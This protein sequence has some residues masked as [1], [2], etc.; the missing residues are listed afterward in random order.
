MNLRMLVDCWGCRGT[1]A[2]FCAACVSQALS[3]RHAR[4]RDFASDKKQLEASMAEAIAAR[5]AL[6]RQRAER[7]THR[8]LIDELNME[9]KTI[10]RESRCLEEEMSPCVRPCP[11]AARHQQQRL[12]GA[13]AIAQQTAAAMAAATPAAMAPA[14]LLAPRCLRARNRQLLPRRALPPLRPLISSSRNAES[15]SC[16]SSFNFTMASG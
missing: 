15:V 1:S 10:K 4:L 6:L 14:R 11:G 7:R 9:L 16:E 12:A 8:A 3:E 13:K 5:E 2:R